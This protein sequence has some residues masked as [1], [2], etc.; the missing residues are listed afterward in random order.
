MSEI[1]DSLSETR[2]IC[3]LRCFGAGGEVAD[4]ARQLL[5]HGEGLDDGDALR[6]LLHGPDQPGIDQN[7]FRLI[8]R[9]RR[10]M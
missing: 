8:L 3:C 5:L 1:G 10:V 6:G 7:R 2:A 9:T 4:A